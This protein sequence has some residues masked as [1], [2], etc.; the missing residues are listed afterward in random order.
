MIEKI[1]KTREYL[2]YLEEHYNNVQ[3]AWKL[4]QDKCKDMKFIYDDYSYNA[5]DTIIKDHDNSKL[6]AEEFV[7]Y[8]MYFFPVNEEEK[9]N[10]NFNDAWKNH[11]KLNT[12]HWENW[13]KKSLHTFADIFLIHNIVDWIAMSFKFGDTAKNFYEKNKDEI[14]FPAWAEKL[15][16]EI[17]ERIYNEKNRV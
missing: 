3:K 10:S 8:R 2:D 16:Y 15:A 13:T 14:Q 12:H 1:K 17:F 11:K 6:S 9:E 7:Q 5:L 4:L